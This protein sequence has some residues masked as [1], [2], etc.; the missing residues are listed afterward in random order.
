MARINWTDPLLRAAITTAIE[1]V[2]GGVL[3]GNISISLDQ[4][5]RV[6]ERLQDD[7]EGI[8]AAAVRQ[9]YYAHIKPAMIA[10]S[11]P[12]IVTVA[13]REGATVTQTEVIRMILDGQVQAVI[14]GGECR[15]VR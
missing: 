15:R 11:E 12:L 1:A 13:L 9:G 3:N 2:I 8:T 4:W 6:A 14:A 5:Q 7:W 10:N